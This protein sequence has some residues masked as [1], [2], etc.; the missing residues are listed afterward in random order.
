MN[1]WPEGWNENRGDRHGRG[2]AHPQPEGARSM[3]HVQRQQPPRPQRPAGP[4]PSGYGVPPQQAQQ[5]DTF[6]GYD[7]GYNTGQVYG[8]PGGQG[9]PGGPGGHPAGP[10]APPS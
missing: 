3:R 4:P 8:T 2:S 7:S 9:G 1:D 10:P 6:A 5:H